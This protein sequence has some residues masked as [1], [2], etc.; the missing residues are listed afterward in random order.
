MSEQEQIRRK[1]VDSEQNQEKEVQVQKQQN[2]IVKVWNTEDPY[3]SAEIQE[4]DLDVWE[5]N[6][7]TS[8]QPELVL[9]PSE[10][11]MLLKRTLGMK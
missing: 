9:M 7:Y 1:R 8:K 10:Q 11:A 2:K 3:K 4:S 5:K 6:G